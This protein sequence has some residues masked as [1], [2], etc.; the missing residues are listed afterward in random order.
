M[1]RGSQ[2]L[3]Q[4][5]HNG[6]S[7]AT[8]VLPCPALLGPEHPQ[9][10]PWVPAGAAAGRFWGCLRSALAPSLTGCDEPQSSGKDPAGAAGRAGV[11][12]S[13][14]LSSGGLQVGNL[15]LMALLGT[16]PGSAQQHLK[17]SPTKLLLLQRLQ[18]FLWWKSQV[19]NS[20]PGR[21]RKEERLCK[22]FIF[23]L[24]LCS[25]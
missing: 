2:S 19:L 10:L 17:Q 25:L 20:G 16:S 22:G 7:K 12:Q 24:W 14:P 13:P 18:P 1:L 3:E 6:S 8:L 15:E 5:Q 9:E 23:G 4:P 21:K 11:S